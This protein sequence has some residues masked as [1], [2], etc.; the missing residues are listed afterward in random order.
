MCTAD[1]VAAVRAGRSLTDALSAVP[2]QRR[3]GTQALAFAVLRGWGAAHAARC[4]L[5]PRAPAPWVD[6]LLTSDVGEDSVALPLPD[7]K[8]LAV[9]RV[10]QAVDVRL[11]SLDDLGGKR[12]GVL[13]VHDDHD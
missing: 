1:A 8:R 12:F 2:A 9:A 5:A 11:E 4:A 6:A 3:A 7:V 10:D 13:V